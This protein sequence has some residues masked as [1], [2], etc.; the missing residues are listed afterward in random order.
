[1]EE[2]SIDGKEFIELN[3]LIKYLTWVE[4]GGVA[5]ATIGGGNVGVNNEQELRK[6]RKLRVG[7]VIKWGDKSCKIIE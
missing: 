2:F 6:R 7:D 5:N 4:S 3:R 1:M